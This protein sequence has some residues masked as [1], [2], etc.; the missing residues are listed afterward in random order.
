MTE[1]GRTATLATRT[2]KLCAQSHWHLQRCSSSVHS[3]MEQ[4]WHLSRCGPQGGAVQD[5]GCSCDTFHDTT[6]CLPQ[7]ACT[8]TFITT[9]AAEVI[10]RDTGGPTTTSKDKNKQHTPKSPGSV[11]DCSSNSNKGTTASSGNLAAQ[12]LPYPLHPGA[13][14]A[15]G[16]VVL[17]ALMPPEEL[18][19]LS[20]MCLLAYVATSARK[21]GQHPL[22]AQCELG[23]G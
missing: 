9:V 21:V 6:N 8:A 23:Y 10:L 4:H 2:G 12:S 20:S 14:A 17:S 22:Q 15:A 1:L 3:S 7:F 16:A 13:I 19:A 5:Q 18:P 11:P